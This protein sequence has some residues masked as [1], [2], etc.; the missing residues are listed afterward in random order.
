MFNNLLAHNFTPLLWIL[1]LNCLTGVVSFGKRNSSCQVNES[2]NGGDDGV[3]DAAADQEEQKLRVVLQRVL[4][5]SLI[6]EKMLIRFLTDL[7]SVL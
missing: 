2:G 1:S 7:V 3:G 4:M 6:W 5:G